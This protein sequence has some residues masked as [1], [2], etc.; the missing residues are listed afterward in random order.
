MNATSE[1]GFEEG[2]DA[3]LALPHCKP[4]YREE[5]KHF[6]LIKQIVLEVRNSKGDLYFYG[7]SSNQETCFCHT[8]LG[9][10]VFYLLN[11]LGV[12]FHDRPVDNSDPHVRLFIDHARSSG[13]ADLAAHLYP[14]YKH[15]FIQF[16]SKLN[17]FVDALRKGV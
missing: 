6:D 5:Q 11:Y 9:E 15:N 12:V 8:H 2:E 10:K 17:D 14:E 3:D 1:I 13:L 4:D 7:T 16:M